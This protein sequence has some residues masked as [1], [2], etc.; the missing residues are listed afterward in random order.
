MSSKYSKDVFHVISNTHWDR[1]W[2]LAF[3]R[4]RQNL[5]DMIDSVLD[6]LENEPEYRAFHLDSQ[7]IVLKDYLEIKPQNKD[8]IIQL[9][10]DKRLLHGPWYILPE[11]FQVGGENLIR[12]LLRGHQVSNEYGGVSKIGYS[13]FSWGQ[14]SQ[15]PQI[16]NEFNINLIMFYRGIN[17]QESPRAEFLW[18]G[19]DNTEMISSR[20]S[21]F[22]R[23]NFFFYIYR[24]VAHNEKF[25]DTRQDWGEDTLFHLADPM[26]VDEDYTI[27]SD[28]TEYHPGHI[29]TQTQKLIDDQYED[30]TT[31]HKVWMEGHD[32][33][34]PNVQT[35]QIIRDIREKMPHINVK[36]S[37]LE[38]Y[39][40]EL[41]RSVDRNALDVVE[42]ERRSAQNNYRCWNLYGYTTSARMYLKQMNFDVERW[43]QYYA[44]PFNIFSYLLGRD[45]NDQ[46]PEQAWEFLIQNSA[47]D[48]IGGCSLERI[49]EDMVN[50][51]KQSKE[52]S[53]G[54]FERA[55]SYLVRQLNTSEFATVNGEDQKRGIFLT[56]INPLHYRRTD[57]TEAYVD[58]PKEMDRGGFNL[59]D[60]QGNHLEKEVLERSEFMPVVEQMINRPKYLE[61][62]RYRVLIK[63]ENLAPY[64]LKAYHVQPA[65]PASGQTDAA[66]D[67]RLE[68]QY[69]KVAFNEDGSLNVTD[70]ERGVTYSQTGY[71]FDEGE[72]GQAWIH[73]SYGM[74]VDTLHT[75]ARISRSFTSSMFN[76]VQVEHELK[77]PANL[78]ERGKEKPGMAT[79][80]VVLRVGLKDG[81]RHLEMNVDVDN[82][83]ESHRLRMMFPS[84]LQATHSYGEGQ[85]DVVRRSLERPDTS[86]WVEQPMY[87]FPMHHFVD[88]TDGDKGM[89]V[90]VDG[91]KEYEVLP[92]DHNTLAITLSRGFEYKINPAAPQDYSHEKG[93]Q[94][95]GK[96]SY[97]LA[98]YPHKGDWQQGEV[99]KESFLFNYPLRVVQS[100]PLHGEQGAEMSFLEI[101]PEDLVVSSV[102]KAEDPNF[103]GFVLRLY[104]PTEQ[105]IDGHA[106]LMETPEDVWQV[107]ME[108]RFLRRPDIQ[109][110]GAFKFHAGPK[111]ILTFKI[112]Y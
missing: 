86:D 28:H 62:I 84:G 104:N 88:L 32:A 7:S 111:Q 26:Q 20:F 63:A 36:H 85:F 1:E 67:L 4:N 27:I 52:I 54:L 89:A 82:H 47:H 25:S 70:K 9:A 99:Y 69:L 75:Q 109:P 22:P 31:P 102:K 96:N 10:R 87:D 39:A 97:R 14:I 2:R 51:Y 72:A 53:M 12:N 98:L 110:D 6:I 41:Y 46:Y 17:A 8:R 79:C 38:E 76:E 5:V 94:M 112:K 57:L 74:E 95:L 30:F 21:T 42:G 29:E 64:T 65:A 60:P 61:M 18:R 58:I 77:L 49:H 103:Q 3:Q 68:N 107:T 35:A 105:D 44:E 16:Y 48:S 19:A 81:S 15:L 55:S 43:I 33:S 23:Y 24:P 37:T 71:F 34:G 90:L 11:E 13:P 40:D 91:L 83:A 56:L 45:I 106:R 100:G 92:D 50:R 108:E 66:P 101:L 80:S 59:V 93:S 73:E 78:E